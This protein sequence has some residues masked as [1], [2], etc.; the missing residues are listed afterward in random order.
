MLVACEIWPLLCCAAPHCRLLL[1]YCYFKLHCCSSSYFNQSQRIDLGMHISFPNT[2][3]IQHGFLSR[4]TLP[5]TC[6]T[7]CDTSWRR[8]GVEL[9]SDISLQGRF[10]SVDIDGFLDFPSKPRQRCSGVTMFEKAMLYGQ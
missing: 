8:A 10:H 3:V 4:L 7:S 5:W 2:S 6:H 1:N 9:L